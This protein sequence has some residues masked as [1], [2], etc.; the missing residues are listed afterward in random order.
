MRGSLLA[1]TEA[2]SKHPLAHHLSQFSKLEE[3]TMM[4][5]ESGEPVTSQACL[6]SKHAQCKKTRD[7]VQSNAKD[8]R[9]TWSNTIPYL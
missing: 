9:G 7:G 6:R 8:F 1:Q 2:R 3:L 5:A 4:F